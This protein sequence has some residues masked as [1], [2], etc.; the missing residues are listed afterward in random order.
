MK[1][2]RKMW[3]ESEREQ[4]KQLYPD[5]RTNELMDIFHCNEGQLYNQAHFLGLKKSPE[6]L[7]EFVHTLDPAVG[8]KYRYKKGRTSENK[9]IPMSPELYAKCQPTMFRKGNEPHNTRFDGALS[10]RVDKTGNEYLYIRVEKSKWVLYHRLFWEQE[11]GTIPKGMCVAFI[12]GN[13]ANVKLSNLELITR[14]VNM[15]RNTIHQWPSEMKTVI[16]LKNKL[17]NK[18][19]NHGKK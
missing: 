14:E 3:S 9:G 5:T 4:L 12:D 16:K 10:S 7:K 1:T 13:S 11:H 8:E 15:L 17:I 2:K 19:K 18:I 6:Y